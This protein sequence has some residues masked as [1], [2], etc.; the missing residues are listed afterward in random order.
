VPLY[1]NCH[2]TE[3]IF[4]D[5]QTFGTK[6]LALVLVPIGQGRSCVINNQAHCIIAISNGATHGH[7]YHVKL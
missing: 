6:A 7:L 4:Y 5:M 3:N 2:N 1:K